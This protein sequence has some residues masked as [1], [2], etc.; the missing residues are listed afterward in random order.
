MGRAFVVA[1]MLVGA[2]AFGGCAQK[3]EEQKAAEGKSPA[4]EQPAAEQPAA[5]KPAAE[6]PAGEQPVAEQPATGGE[7][8]SV[9]NLKV[10]TYEVPNLTMD[11]AKQLTMALAVNDG[12]VSAKADETAGLFMVTYSA[13]CPYGILSVLQG[14]APDAKLKGVAAR[15]GGAPEQGGCGGCPKKST[16]DGSH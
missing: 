5:E 16:C 11:L 14:V 9:P 12:V 2:L 15:E 1:L 6:K 7:V 4:A 3:Q 10:A 8:A 13:G